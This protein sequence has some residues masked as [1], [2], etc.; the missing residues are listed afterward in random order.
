MRLSRDVLSRTSP[1]GV[2]PPVSDDCAPIGSTVEA[3]R[4]QR[5]DLGLRRRRADAGGEAARK[6]RGVLEKR[7]QHVR[8][9]A[10]PRRRGR[11]PAGRAR[12]T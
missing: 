10:D 1:R 2:A 6:M 7:R 9:A 3:A 8:I 12:M 5:G 11:R 4:T